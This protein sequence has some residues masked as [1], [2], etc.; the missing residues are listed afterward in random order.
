MLQ[1]AA[2]FAIEY[3]SAVL[4]EGKEYFGLEVSVDQIP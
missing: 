1:D 4:G 2:E 3:I